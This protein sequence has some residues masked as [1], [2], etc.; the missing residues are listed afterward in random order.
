MP[1][2]PGME[3]GPAPP[4]PPR[5]LP[6]GFAFRQRFI[7]NMV[8]MIGLGFT[9]VGSIVALAMVAAPGWALLIPGFIL[10]GGLS[11]VK[12]GIQTANRTLDAFC[13][14]R[15]VKGRIASVRQDPNTKVNG[16]SPWKIVFTFEMDGHTYDGETLTWEAA[17]SNRFYGSP[18]VWVLVV[19]GNPQRNTLYPPVK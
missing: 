18:P 14:G 4:P 16:Q 17:T 1:A 5:K 9:A 13:N 10:L 2:P 15:A 8:T 12:H 7:G 3:L 6:E 19:D 11:M